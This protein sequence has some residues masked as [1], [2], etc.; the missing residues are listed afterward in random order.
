[1]E[2]EL[3]QDDIFYFSQFEKITRVTA[4]EYQQ[5]E[6]AMYFVVDAPDLGKAIGKNASNIEKLSKFFRKKVFI[7]PDLKDMEAFL[8]AFF[9]NINI[10][11]VEVMNIMG[12][13]EAIVTLDEQHRGFAIGKGGERIKAAKALLKKRF[14]A[15]LHLKTRRVFENKS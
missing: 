8:R 15:D 13:S 4:L 11:S 5:G 7:V 12:K 1:M 10:I 6:N 14:D 3:N 2:I 9:S